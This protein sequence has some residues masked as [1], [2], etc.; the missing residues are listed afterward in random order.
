[1]LKTNPA[2]SV[3]L[4]WVDRRVSPQ[5]VIAKVPKHSLGSS[6]TWLVIQCLRFSTNVLISW[7]KS[8][9]NT[10][11]KAVISAQAKEYWSITLLFFL[12]VLASLVYNQEYKTQ[13]KIRQSILRVKKL[14]KY[15]IYMG[16][17]NS[18]EEI[19]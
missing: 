6:V 9:N 1:M 8:L 16:C 11:Q 18:V 15:F 12:L 19:H 5:Y 14:S 4:F 2:I 10:E 13:N 17:Y 3:V 7:P